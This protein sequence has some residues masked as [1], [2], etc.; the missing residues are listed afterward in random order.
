MA[1]TFA[2]SASTDSSP[3]S[4]N[5]LTSWP[6]ARRRPATSSHAHA[7]SQNPGTRTIGADVMRESY[8]ASA[9]LRSGGVSGRSDAR[10][11]AGR[12]LDADA[13]RRLAAVLVADDLV[14]PLRGPLDLAGLVGHDIVVVVLPGKLHRGVALAQLEL[15][16]AFRRT[17]PQPMEQVL[18]R[19]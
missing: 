8:G 5:A 14:D 7:P 11:V 3:G 4:V 19:R 13:A 10:P 16:D 9:D 15:V 17:Q 6:S 2:R 18:L 1:W 12:G